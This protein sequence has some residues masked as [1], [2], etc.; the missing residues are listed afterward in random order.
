M[1][2]AIV[3]LALFIALIA[4]DADA[5]VA[6]TGMVL[7]GGELDSSR[8]EVGMLVEVVHGKGSR[9]RFSGEWAELATVRGVIES[10]NWDRRQLV[11]TREGDGRTVTIAVDRIQ[12]MTM[13]AESMDSL[14]VKKQGSSFLRGSLRVGLKV[15]SGTIVGIIFSPLG[16]GIVGSGSVEGDSGIGTAVGAYTAFG[17][18]YP[19]G[20]YLA[21]ARESSLWLTLI[22]GGLGWWGAASLLD[23][24]NSSEWAAWVTFFGAPVL[25]SELS[26]MDAVTGGPKRPKQPQDLRFSFGLVPQLQKSLLAVATLR[27]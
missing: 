16:S 19:I 1:P 4:T 24:P 9:H 21:D 6:P 22:G 10:V 12:T 5:A 11:V 27:F 17:L 14:V 13:I 15:A 18:G 2:F 8:V 7:T 25:T 23:S 3:A 20:V 26:R